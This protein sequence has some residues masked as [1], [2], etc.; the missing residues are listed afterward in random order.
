M[1]STDEA[2]KVAIVRRAAVSIGVDRVV[3]MGPLTHAARSARK[4]AQWATEQG[5]DVALFV[6]DAPLPGGHT[7]VLRRDILSAIKKFVK[8]HVYTQLIV[9]FGGHGILKAPGTEIWLLSDAGNDAAEG[10]NLL[11]D[12]EHARLTGI[13][14]VV[15]ISDACRVT[16][17]GL[18]LSAINGANIFP[19]TASPWDAET[20]VDIYFAT[21]PGDPAHEDPAQIPNGYGIFTRCFL[22]LVNQPTPEMIHEIIIRRAPLSIVTSDSLKPALEQQVMKEVQSFGPQYRQKPQIRVESDLPLF[23]ATVPVP[24]MGEPGPDGEGSRLPGADETPGGTGG[25]GSSILPGS[26]SDPR[27]PIDPRLEPAVDTLGHPEYYPPRRRRQRLL[28]TPV[29]ASEEIGAIYE[30]SEGARDLAQANAEAREISHE[31]P[32]GI[33]TEGNAVIS[34]VGANLEYAV[35]P[36]FEA[37]AGMSS[38]PR[39][40]D[41]TVSAIA[42]R[43]NPDNA[44]RKPTSAIL[45]LDEGFGTIVP[46]QAGK[47][48]V[49]TVRDGRVVSAQQTDFRQLPFEVEDKIRQYSAVAFDHALD[50]DLQYMLEYQMDP[51]LTEFTWNSSELTSV[52]VLRGYALAEAGLFD[53]NF[54]HTAS[55]WDQIPFDLAMLALRSLSGRTIDDGARNA[56]LSDRVMPSAPQLTRGWLLFDKRH[57]LYRPVHDELRAHLVPALWTTFDRVGTQIAAE[58]AV[59]GVS[60]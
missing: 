32:G 22:K 42:M 14:H 12:T 27:Q 21:K 24:P 28:D 53:P 57:P 18:Q 11:I 39:G 23:I 48:T 6:D 19:N 51:R 47:A 38:G 17:N 35:C 33:G 58:A 9:Y 34:V 59:Q 46:V 3:G 2:V 41:R 13:P 50:G 36:D 56:F 7:E 37:V 44:F 31:I 52:D 29:L 1:L 60:G 15:F 16:P 25:P 20:E 54:F 10:V 30:R 49:V 4:F 43:P 40:L 8:A 55:T 26:S 45:T 5:C